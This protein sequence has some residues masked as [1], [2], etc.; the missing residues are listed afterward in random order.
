MNYKIRYESRELELTPTE[1]S[2]VLNFPEQYPN[3][4]RIYLAQKEFKFMCAD[5][6]QRQYMRNYLM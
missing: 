3:F 1:L 5:A 4:R 6:L 2:I